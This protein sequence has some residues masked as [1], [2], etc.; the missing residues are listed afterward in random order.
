[1]E[2]AVGKEMPWEQQ[3]AMLIE[4]AAL[5][6]PLLYQSL[7]KLY[8]EEKGREIYDD[9]FEENF[10]KRSARFEDKDIGDLMMV[11]IDMF[12]AMGWKLW[13]EKKEENGTPVWFEHLEKCPHLDATRKYNLPEPCPLICDMDCTLGQKYKVAV[14]ERLKHM[15]AGD[16]EC[17]F[18]ITRCT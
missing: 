10:K 1:M 3:K 15:P 4:M 14:W 2:K 7:V 17:C 5:K 12:P 8:G 13:V 16:S 18:K 6:L 9:L 11:E